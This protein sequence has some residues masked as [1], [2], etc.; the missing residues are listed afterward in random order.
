VSPLPVDSI[1]P[2]ILD[3][4]QSRK[5]LVIEAPPGAG[6]TTRVPPALLELGPG[7][8]IVLE[9]RRLAARMA[10]RRVA[11]VRGEKIGGLVGYQ[12][13]FE[14]VAS[15]STRLRF[16]TEGVLT[17]RFLSDPDLARAAV[18]VLDEFHERHVET[19]LA[20]ALLRRLQRT[21]R[22]DLRI[23]VMSATLESAPVAEF[24][25]DCDVLRSE[26]RMYPLDIRYTPHSSAALE[27]QVASALAQVL[28]SGNRGHVL[29]FLP[30][31]A[32]IRRAARSCERLAARTGMLIAPLHGDLPPE[33]QDRAV[34]P[35]K[36]RRLIL[37]TNV[38]ESSITIDGVT[39]VIDSGLARIASDDPWTGL[40]S[41][42]VGRVSRASC[43]QRAGRAG[44]TAPGLVIRLYSEDDFA[45]RAEQDAPEILRREL[46]HLLLDLHAMNATGL[47]WL[48]AP[49]APG[50]DA[51]EALLRRLA[52][53]DKHGVVTPGGLEMSRLPL[54]PRLSR[55]VLESQRR[56]GGEDGCA[57]AAV[58]S[59]AERLE[60]PPT[61]HTSSDLIVLAQREWQYGTKRAYDQIRRIVRPSGRG[62][63]DV[64]VRQAI[65]A[66]FPDRVA[67]RRQGREYQLSSGMALLAE[68]STVDAEFVV[69]VDVEMRR[70]RSLPLIRFASAIE[71]EWLIDLFF[72]R[73]EER[74]G[75]EWN[76]AAERV[77]Q[78]SAMLYDGL[79][80]AETRSGAPDPVQASALVAEKALETDL[81]R[82]VD[83][84]AL[85]GFLAR[86][87]FAAARGFG[88]ML[89]E[90][91]VRG[92]L[93]N[94]AT[95]LR[96]FAELERADLLGS[97]RHLAPARLEEIAPSRITLRGGRSVPVHYVEGQPPWIASRL[98]DFFGMRETPR[99]AGE[100]VVVHLLAPNQR[101]VQMT[102]DLAS[103]WQRLYPQVRRELM[104]RYPKHKWPEDPV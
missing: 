64:A 50:L 76:R 83:R 42:D 75:V 92:E 5:N 85:A 103:F 79:V 29:V 88:Q 65:L 91:A 40:P 21:R 102:S 55:L 24:L 22:P 82:F 13:R 7:E 36:Q 12:V 61:H 35:S 70:D 69:A 56:G 99:V 37:S 97:L 1:L 33:E 98:Q 87:A 63:D 26:G 49:P 95:G 90:D 44:R 100:P 6:K 16:F 10:A 4:L 74:D 31:A 58:L 17:R 53:V 9:P 3:R 77:D 27:E 2:E 51:A 78:R 39:A 45:R 81:G 68:S 84:E 43:N 94:I 23:V 66:A 80:I 25:G 72:D 15:R 71:P 20:L 67:R 32:E 46:S 30:G 47:D 14:E 57:V 38:A 104:R 41:L 93:R 101:P 73:I 48:T 34:Q 60:G 52:A 18:I 89:T 11:E 19:D 59:A 62:K 54:H 28:D 96:S 86:V 8:V